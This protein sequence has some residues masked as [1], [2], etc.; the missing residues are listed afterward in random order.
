MSV[1]L[2][3]N[4]ERLVLVDDNLSASL[5]S[6]CKAFLDMVEKMHF[7]W[8][9]AQTEETYMVIEAYHSANEEKEYAFQKVN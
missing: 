8:F 6:W 7:Q 5:N 9:V 1:F 4:L 2:F 3:S